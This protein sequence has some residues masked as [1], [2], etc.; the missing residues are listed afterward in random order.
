MFTWQVKSKVLGDVNND[1]EFNVA[2]AVMLHK[3]LL[4]VPNVRL[5]NWKNGD[6]CEDN[7]IDVFD[8]CLMKR[9]LIG[10]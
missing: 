1:G 3:W 4:A 10:K 5:A 2:D 7:R 6:L 9:V 8:L